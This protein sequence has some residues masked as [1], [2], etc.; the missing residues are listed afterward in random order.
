MELLRDAFRKTT[1]WFVFCY[2]KNIKLLKII[3]KNV[4]I[5][6]SIRLV[7]SEGYR[8]IILNYI[9]LILFKS[10]SVTRDEQLQNK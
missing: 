9:I 2:E 7:F 5:S 3:K 1:N 10:V 6:V 8:H 4:V